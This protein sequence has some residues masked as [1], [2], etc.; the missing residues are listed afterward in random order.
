ME[1]SCNIT[2]VFGLALAYCLGDLK[3]T[4][5]STDLPWEICLKGNFS[6]T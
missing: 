6:K 4:K 3:S 1:S 2:G 5:S